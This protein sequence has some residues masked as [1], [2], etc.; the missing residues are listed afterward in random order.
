MRFWTKLLVIR[1]I[2]KRGKALYW[3]SKAKSE[4]PIK[5][6]DR[7]SVLKTCNVGV[8]EAHREYADRYVHPTINSHELSTLTVSDSLLNIL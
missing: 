7:E 5:N 1:E 6:R 8:E 3:P 2:L 4:I